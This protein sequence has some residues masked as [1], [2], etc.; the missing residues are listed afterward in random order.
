M[1]LVVLRYS[2]AEG[3]KIQ[4]QLRLVN[5]EYLGAGS[6]LSESGGAVQVDNERDNVEVRY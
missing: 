6:P 5:I 4:R 1:I 3:L 2:E